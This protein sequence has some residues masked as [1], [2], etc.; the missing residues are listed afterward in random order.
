MFLK[1]FPDCLYS[2]SVLLSRVLLSRVSSPRLEP[3]CPWPCCVAE[4][5]LEFP[6][7]LLTLLEAQLRVHNLLRIMCKILDSYL[8]IWNSNSSGICFFFF[9]ITV[10]IQFFV[11]SMGGWLFQD[12]EWL[13]PSP[14]WSTVQLVSHV[15][16][17]SQRSLVYFPRAH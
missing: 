2:L 10:G 13:T 3:N 6:I 11:Q 14:L 8:P 16:A 12:T 15:I 1:A 9:V 17:P 4:D 5:G 7:P